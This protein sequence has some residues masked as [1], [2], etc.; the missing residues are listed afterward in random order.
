MLGYSPM[1]APLSLGDRSRI[2]LGHTMASPTFLST[3]GVPIIDG[4][5]IAETDTVGSPAVAVI[6]ETMARTFWPKESAVGHTVQVLNGSQT[7]SYRIVRCI[8][9]TSSMA[10]S[11]GR[12]RSPTLRIVSV[13]I[14]PTSSSS[15]ARTAAQRRCSPACV[16]SCSPWNR[17]LS[18]WATRR[19]SRAWG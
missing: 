4:R 12:T 15:P 17:A 18:S 6:N 7:R 11:S 9:T 10:C 3:L 5:G 19:W 13:P 2:A 1:M 8:A 14:R 16:E